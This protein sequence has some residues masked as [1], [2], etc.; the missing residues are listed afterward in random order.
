MTALPRAARWYIIAM[1]LTAT[2][3]IVGTLSRYPL[4]YEHLQLLLIWLPLYVMADYFEVQIA[5]GD[6][7]PVRMS[8]AEAPTIFLLAIGGPP[9]VIGMAI[10][11]ALADS[12]QRRPW[13]KVLFNASQRSIT[14]L[15]ALLVYT[16][17]NASAAVPFSGL[18]GILTLI[19]V[20]LIYYACNTVFVSTVLA[21]TTGQKLLPLYASSF[22]LV[23]WVHFITLPLGGVLAALW[24]I[25]PWL[26]LP[27]ILPLIMAQRSFK[28]L[29]AWQAESQRSKALAHESQQLAGKLERLQDTA[30]AM[31]ASLEPLPL[32]ETVST[33]L[34]LLLDASASWVVLLDEPAP[35]LVAAR[36]TPS[37]RLQDAALYAAEL[38]PHAVRQ[39][40]ASD[41]ARLA[42]S[43]ALPWQTLLI[44]PL[45]LESRLLGGICLASERTIALAEDDRRVLLAFAA[46]AALA[47]EHAQ[48][49]EELR[50]KQD[51]LVRSSKLAALGT[52]SAGI[53]HEF[54]NLLAGILGYAQLGLLS[55]DVEEKNEA[56]DVAARACLRG[57]GITSS[58]LTFARRSDPQR[59]LYQVRDAVEE[60]L[61][62]VERELAKLNIRVERRLEPVPLTICDLGQI[63]QVLLNLITNARDA[64][65]KQDG[66]V[67]TVEL[68]QRGGQIELVVSDTGSGIPEHLLQQVFQPFMTTKGALG[69][70]TTPGT[71][72]GLAISYGIVEGHGGTISVASTVGQ[73]TTMTVRLPIIAEL[74]QPAAAEGNTA[75]LSA[76]R[77]LVVD[78]EQ[79]VAESLGRLLTSYGH[80]VVLAADGEI[81]LLRYR[82]QPF[83]LVI[84]DAVMPVMDGAE[85]VTR[86]RSIDAHAHILALSGQTAATRVERMLQAGAF[87]FVSKPFVVDELLDA[88]AR[89]MRSRVLSAA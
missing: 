80:Q 45:A 48:L 55:D 85:F 86:L 20:A 50:H 34:A 79:V 14:Y 18:R 70:S 54:N 1:W 32:L 31:I 44:I 19:A 75:R 72:L 47:M 37:P 21:L 62:L 42:G 23:Q 83:D 82:E 81:G 58:L 87:G 74:P 63:G 61:A 24:K 7:P 8:V 29:G 40:D 27:G 17:A 76:L 33:R 46:Q 15:I 38:E 78:D 60:T 65:L 16:S 12:L 66:G 69:G 35:R 11:S 73:G 51:E 77:I 36:G 49:F 4:Y 67:I 59:A 88:I 26:I 71:G 39:L 89:G 57:R 53:A 43:G 6:R 13:Y 10:G 22:R 2:A 25:D 68:A 84:T 3:L 41:L 52:F 64:M 5:L 30:T 28:A 56:L 9:C